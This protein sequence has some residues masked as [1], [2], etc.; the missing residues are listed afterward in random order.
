MN[1]NNP[2]K[3]VKHSDLKRASDLSEFKSECPVCTDGVLLVRRDMKTAQLLET[4]MCISCGQQFIYD[5]IKGLRALEGQ[6]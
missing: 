3:H 1:Y 4:D 5:D 6:T 2:P